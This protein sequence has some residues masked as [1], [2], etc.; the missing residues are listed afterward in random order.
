[1]VHV[2]GRGQINQLTRMNLI[3]WCSWFLG[4]FSF[5]M[6][7]VSGRLVPLELLVYMMD[8]MSHHPR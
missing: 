7:V 4:A 1:M 6:Q 5:V 2:V 3:D 8:H